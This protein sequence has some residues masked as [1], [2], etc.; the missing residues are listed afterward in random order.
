MYSH[1]ITALSLL[2]CVATN[3][4]NAQVR[5][6]SDAI[7]LDRAKLSSQTNRVEVYQD[8]IDVE[9]SLGVSIDQLFGAIELKLGRTFESANLGGKIKVVVSGVSCMERLSTH[10][11]P[12]AHH[13]FE[14]S[15][16]PG[17]QNKIQFDT[18]S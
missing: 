1:I 16:L 7:I 4:A 2:A 6:N 12:T 5:A 10:E 9:D 17:I 3:L 15:C 13:F 18:Y 14:C 11:R 8:G